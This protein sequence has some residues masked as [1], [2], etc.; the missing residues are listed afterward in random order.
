MPNVKTRT[1]RY[2][3]YARRTWQQRR[4]F[5]QTAPAKTNANVACQRVAVWHAFTE[6]TEPVNCPGCIRMIS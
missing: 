2:V 3:H 6:T 5:G 1:G 4:L